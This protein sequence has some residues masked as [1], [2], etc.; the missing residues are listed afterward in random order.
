MKEWERPKFA[1]KENDVAHVPK[2]DVVKKLP[3]PERPG[4][5][6]Q[7]EQLFILRAGM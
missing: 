5:T 6:T 4:G 2:S 3:Q 7:R 1:I